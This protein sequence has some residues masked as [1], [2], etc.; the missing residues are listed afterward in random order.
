MKIL[1]CGD[2]F[3]VTDPDFPGLHWTEKII[4]SY[5]DVEICN[6]AHGGCSNAMI[7]L[8]LLQ[9]FILNPNFVIL[10]FTNEHRYEL[11]KDVDVVPTDLTAQGL[12]N[13]QKN[14]YTTNMYVKDKEIQKW[15]GGKCS[16]N[17]EKLKNYFYISF[18]LQ[19]LQQLNI[20]FAFSLGGFEYEQD[21]SAFINSNYMYNFIKDYATSKL[22]TNLWYHERKARPYFHVDNDE[23]Q[24][25]FANECVFLINAAKKK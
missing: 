25:L 20:P 15:M 17:F 18:C 24:T 10:S 13:Y 3:S 2:S 19:T 23:I 8:Q 7:T 5:P 4:N 11:D 9:G 21:Y 16:D 1:V 12:S 6:L 14:R 22:K